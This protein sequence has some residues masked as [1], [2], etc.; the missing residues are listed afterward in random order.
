VSKKNREGSVVDRTEHDAANA[1]QAESLAS[2][3]N[4][5][6]LGEE[7]QGAEDATVH[8]AVEADG[9]HQSEVK[10]TDEQI[11]K[12][13]SGLTEEQLAVVETLQSEIAALSKP[14][15]V[16]S[17]SKARPNVVY[18][19]M[20]KPPKWSDTPQVA[21]I[22]QIL[23]GQDKREMT[24]PEIFDLIKAG[25]DAGILRTRQNPVRIFQYYRSDLIKD[26][27]LRYQ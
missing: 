18:T 3:V 11:E 5:D 1:E 12:L 19:L 10:L 6:N 17:G 13:K 7:L 22:E 15:R 25:A 26:N 14:K 16:A 21:Q 4:T 9:A 27:V 23:F 2:E 24:E 8:P 20:N